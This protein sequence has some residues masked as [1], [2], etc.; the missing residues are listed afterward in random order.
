M[1]G[2]VTLIAIVC[3]VAGELDRYM[4]ENRPDA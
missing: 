3:N 1:D 2:V 4:V